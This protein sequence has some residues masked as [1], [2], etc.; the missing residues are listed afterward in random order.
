MNHFRIY[1]YLAF[2]FRKPSVFTSF[3]PFPVSVHFRIYDNG[4]L[5]RL[6]F[7]FPPNRLYPLPYFFC[8]PPNRLYPL[9]YFFYFPKIVYIRY[10][11]TVTDTEKFHHWFEPTFNFFL[12]RS[13]TTAMIT[14]LLRPQV[15][16][17]RSIFSRAAGI[18]C[19]VDILLTL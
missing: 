8:F 13:K 11:N 14:R 2:P 1:L 17:S 16:F 10:R 7:C 3:G 19:R 12:D 4:Y 15:V 6:L 9:P 18:T 5:T